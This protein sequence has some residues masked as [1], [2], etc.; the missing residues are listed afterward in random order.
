MHYRSNCFCLAGLVL[1][2]AVFPRTGLCQNLLRWKLK[3]GETLRY[4]FRQLSQSQTTG[5]AKPTTVAL[6]MSMRLAWEV[7]QVDPQG[8][9]LIEQ[10]IEKLALTMKVDELAPLVYDSSARAAASGPGKEIA[11][12]AG[13][14][15]GGKCGVKLSD[16]G[17]VLAV[18]PSAS[19][20]KILEGKTA[21][22]LF[23]PEGIS[24][25]VSH[26]SI[27]LP[28][29]AAEPGFNWEVVQELPSPVGTLH[30]TH[31]YQYAGMEPRDGRNQA[32]I[33]AKTGIELAP[34]KTADQPAS[35]RESD[36]TA[37]YWFDVSLGR[38]AASDVQQRLVTERR[39]RERTIRVTT[40]SSV[41]VTLVESGPA[42]QN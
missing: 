8:N 37:T 35:L 38:F 39:Y 11:E 32:K 30:L 18:E 20:R 13:A 33:L 19:L 6:E 9:F 42:K 17:V 14:L 34:L 16:R 4:D 2:A 21:S 12:S 27:A 31:R 24:R 28:E 26:A 5:A 41:G 36:Q 40:T 22:E 15:V 1:L 29:K 3:P 10:T 23:T 7:N 25:I